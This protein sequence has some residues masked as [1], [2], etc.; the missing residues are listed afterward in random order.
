MISPTRYNILDPNCTKGVEDDKKASSNLLDASKLDTELFRLGHTKVLFFFHER[1]KFGFF[2]N[3]L[4]RW[5]KE[6]RSPSF[7]NS[8]YI[9]TNDA[10][11]SRIRNWNSS[12]WH[13]PCTRNLGTL[14]NMRERMFVVC[15]WVRVFFHSFPC[16]VV[17]KSWIL[18][19]SEIPWPG[20]KLPEHS[21]NTSV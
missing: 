2:F 13:S 9:D 14:V 8:R 11:G 3:T 18:E 5:K 16:L 15:V 4:F 1:K 21:L 10:I 6:E 12:C 19:W 7:R 20:S 17:I